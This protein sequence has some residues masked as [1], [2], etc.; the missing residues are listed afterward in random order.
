MTELPGPLTTIAPPLRSLTRPAI[1]KL[2][3][4]VV[5]DPVV[6][7]TQTNRSKELPAI[8]GRES[9]FMVPDE[10]LDWPPSKVV[11]RETFIVEIPVALSS[12]RFRFVH[13]TEE[14][15]QPR[16]PSSFL[17]TVCGNP[18]GSEALVEQRYKRDSIVICLFPF[19]YQFQAVTDPRNSLNFIAS[20][21]PG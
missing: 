11:T 9:T 10:T 20:S 21:L 13:S 6:L 16:V 2:V 5:V 4:S 3:W 8:L 7:V 15:I 1:A 14:R 12:S 19:R 17:K 18:F